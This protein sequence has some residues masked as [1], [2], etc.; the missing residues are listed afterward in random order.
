MLVRIRATARLAIF[1]FIFII[2]KC[3][4]GDFS[5]TVHID[6]LIPLV[7][8]GLM[9]SCHL[10]G[11]VPA[12]C[13]VH[14]YKWERSKNMT[15]YVCNSTPNGTEL[16]R[17]WDHHRNGAPKG[18]YK[19]GVVR[20]KFFHVHIEDTGRYVCAVTGDGVYQEA[21][22][23]VTV[24]GFGSTP[25][26]T[27]EQQHNNSATLRCTSQGWYPHPEVLW[28]DSTRQNITAMAK[29]RI[30][31]DMA[32]FYQI[33]STILIVDSSSDTISCTIINPVLKRQRKK[34]IP[35]SGF[36][37][38]EAEH[39]TITAVIGENV[40]LPCRLITKHLPSSM[41][42]KWRKVGPREDKTI[43]F[44]L[45][46][47]SS[48]LINSYPQNDKCP[49]G[50]LSPNGD[51]SRKWLR[52]EYEKKAGV[53]K[54]KE[55]GKGNISL[56]LNNIQ[57]EDEGKYVCSAT[58]SLFHREI[59]INVL[60]IEVQNETSSQ[61]SEQKIFGCEY[62]CMLLCIGMLL[63]M[64]IMQYFCGK[65]TKQLEEEIAELRNQLERKGD[66]SP[67]VSEIAEK[68]I[69]DLEDKMEKFQEK[70]DTEKKRGHAELENLQKRIEQLH[71]EIA[72]LRNLLDTERKKGHAETVI[73]Q[74]R[75]EQFEEEMENWEK[76]IKDLKD[77]MEK[78]QEQMDTERKRGHAE[79]EN[80]QKRMEQLEEEMAELRD[81]L[82]ELRNKLER[83]GDHSP[84][85]NWEKKIKDL[86][87]KIE[88]LQEEMER[89][90]L[91]N[92]AADIT[93]NA[94]TAHPNLSVAGDKKNFTHEAQPQRI[95]PNPERFDATVCVLGSGGFSSGKH[96][97][98]V[99][100]GN[101]TDW[102]LGVARKSIQRKGKLSLSPKEGFWVLGLSGKDYWAKTDPW[103]RV[104]VQKKLKKT[105]I[106]L[107][108]KDRQV[109]F[110]N[111][112]DMSVLFTFNDC[113]FSGEI[114]PFFKN[115]HKE[116][117][118]RICS[119]K[120]E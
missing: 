45:Y 37:D 95:P 91:R 114:C 116:T 9:L 63:C 89:I 51:N 60:V 99:D 108:Y 42:L 15:L 17:D 56:K 62:V 18:W 34:V 32:G 67:A 22:T 43:C 8:Q 27:I 92:A 93:L 3:L 88:K 5:L 107:S 41:E 97:W 66:H 7:G 26:L 106:Y 77:K 58:A 54:G 39:R 14:W 61:V 111:G 52:K 30:L 10:I 20:V 46:D 2:G 65:C 115:S 119:V 112:T 96:Y 13:Q 101:S 100:V 103:T 55:F 49:V 80:L 1:P 11:Q 120:E 81:K 35:I 71:K 64:V 76:K 75:I 73:L 16:S 47:E 82:G 94:E 21:V 4:L 113:S 105:G 110:Y 85:E 59:T 83:K 25:C 72:D 98:E 118:M 74:R 28:T 57:V 70:M 36:F 68:R 33:N 90:R 79:P 31:K 38:V 104:I 109:I 40:I 84:A 50:Y 102:D 12:N 87:D 48:S 19:N 24:A 23:Q 53:F 86:K 69:K 44:Y 29:T 6:P 78:L 117:T